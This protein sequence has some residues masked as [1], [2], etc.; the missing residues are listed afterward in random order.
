MGKLG[1]AVSLGPFTGFFDDLFYD[2]SI[3]FHAPILRASPGWSVDCQDAAGAFSVIGSVLMQY[4]RPMA[5]F[6]DP[7]DE[8][9][10]DALATASMLIAAA[11]KIVV[12]TGAGIST[13]SRIPDFRGPQGVWTK[14]PGAEKQATIQNYV[15]DPEVRIRAWRNRLD[16]PVWAAEPNKGHY[17]LLGLERQRKLTAL[18]TQNIDG[19]HHEAGSSAD[20]IVEVHGTVREVVCLSCDYRR[21]MREA[22]DRVRSGDDDPR[23]PECEGI[24]K[25]ATISFGQTL[26]EEDLRRAEE[27]SIECDLLL[28]IG[29]TLSVFPIA[30]VVPVAKRTGAKVVIV[31]AEPTAMD[32]LADVLV[33]GSISDVLGSI[34]GK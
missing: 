17:A 5:S 4:G 13:D 29:T 20:R 31:N 21:P 10:K 12:L 8:D 25:S 30:N 24:L 27:A 19:L 28:A 18:I 22:L 23:C 33:R 3:E 6:A 16:S 32:H 34:I 14:N 2:R 15:A 11:T 1:G 9:H 26:I 7:F